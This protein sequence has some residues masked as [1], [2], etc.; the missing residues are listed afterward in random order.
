MLYSVPLLSGRLPSEYVEHLLLLIR[1]Y[2]ISLGWCL[3]QENLDTV[4]ELFIQFVKDFQRLYVDI[5]DHPARKQLC[6]TNLHG[7]I[8]LVPQIRS[9]GPQH[10]WWEWNLET[11]IGEIKA[12]ARSPS[13]IEELPTAVPKARNCPSYTQGISANPTPVS[14]P[15]GLRSTRIGTISPRRRSIIE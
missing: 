9:C 7:L 12:M 4:H 10:V 6:S 3:A 14:P 13:M 8:H 2:D 1:A 11:Y 15:K 5:D